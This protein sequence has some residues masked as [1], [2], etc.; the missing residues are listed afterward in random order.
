MRMWRHR[1]VRTLTALV[2]TGALAVATSST[3]S[4]DL[5]TNGSTTPSTRPSR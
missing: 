3:A 4:A 1:G 2:A 5:V